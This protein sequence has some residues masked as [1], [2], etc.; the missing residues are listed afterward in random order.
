LVGLSF[1]LVEVA[2][3]EEVAYHRQEA[4]MEHRHQ[5]SSLGEE[6]VEE[7]VD[8]FPLVVEEEVEVAIQVQHY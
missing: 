4:F 7:E 8:A 1:H 6:E 2:W 5:H 3:V